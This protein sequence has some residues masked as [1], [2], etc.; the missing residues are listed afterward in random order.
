[1]GSF[2]YMA[3]LW[4]LAL[5][6]D[7]SAYYTGAPSVQVTLWKLDCARLVSV[8]GKLQVFTVPHTHTQSPSHSYPVVVGY[9]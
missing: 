6:G 7:I 3:L 4:L 5:C 2:S 1:M 8:K 9:H